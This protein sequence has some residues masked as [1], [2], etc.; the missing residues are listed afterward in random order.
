MVSG[1]SKAI[2]LSFLGMARLVFGLRELIAAGFIKTVDG[3][4]LGR[5][6]P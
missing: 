4:N 6:L 3:I 5:V 1:S 2:D